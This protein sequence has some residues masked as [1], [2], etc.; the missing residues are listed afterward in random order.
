[1]STD[2]ISFSPEARF[3]HVEIRNSL[4]RSQVDSGE[5]VGPEVP[6][7]R[8]CFDLADLIVQGLAVLESIHSLDH[9]WRLLVYE[10][11]LL[12]SE[13]FERRIGRLYQMWHETSTDVLALYECVSNDYQ[14]Q[15]FETQPIERLRS[16]CREI[17]GLL[18]DDEAFFKDQKLVELRDAAI[19]AHRNG[20]TIEVG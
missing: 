9:D 16:A 2:A 19:D 15:G 18:T 14:K 3:I 8:A 1:M 5:K 13:G 6:P 17:E 7:A 4:Y 20:K 10:K 11:R 12:Y